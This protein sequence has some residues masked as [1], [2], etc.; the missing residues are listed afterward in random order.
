MQYGEYDDVQMVINAVV[1][2]LETLE[3]ADYMRS[4]RI[5][6]FHSGTHF[7]PQDKGRSIL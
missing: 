7:L 5:G 6:V 2:K 4:V 3:I 1:V